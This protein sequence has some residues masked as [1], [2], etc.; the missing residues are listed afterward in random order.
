MAHPA[1]PHRSRPGAKHKGLTMF[2]LPMDTPGITVE[3]VHTMAHRTHQRHLLRR[4]AGGRRGRARRRQRWVAHDDAS[5]SPSSGGS[6]A[7]PTP[8][9][10]CCATSSDW[11]AESAGRASVADRPGARMA[12]IAID[13]QVAALLT[14]RS[15]WIAASGGL[16]GLEG[17]MTKVFAVEAYQKAA[18]WCQ[19]MAGPAGPAAVPRTGRGRRRLRRLRRPPHAGDHHLRRHHRDQPQQHRRAPPRPAQGPPV[20]ASPA[21]PGRASAD[22]AGSVAGLSVTAI[23]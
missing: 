6:W 8:A 21:L 15:A 7:V 18:R 17:S 3:P 11:A 10:P 19:Q 20:D 5:R 1:H 4:R 14:Q 12:R 22:G 16:A 2:I 23:R 13:N 9:C